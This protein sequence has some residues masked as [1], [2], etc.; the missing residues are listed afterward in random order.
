MTTDTAPAAPA[1]TQQDALQVLR[2]AD[3]TDWEM[4]Y[5]LG[6]LSVAAPQEVIEAISRAKAHTKA[7]IL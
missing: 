1:P 3:L 5:V 7:G 6:S 2:D 4:H